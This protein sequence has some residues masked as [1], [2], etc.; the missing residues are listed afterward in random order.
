MAYII[1]ANRPFT[2][3]YRWGRRTYPLSLAAEIQ[4][5]LLPTSPACEAAQFAVAGALEPAGHVGGDAFDYVMDRDHVQLSVTNAMGHDVDTALPATLLVGALRRARRQGADTHTV[6][7]LLK[8]S[9]RTHP[10]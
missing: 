1:I 2:D 10:P 4:Q 5:R 8:V 7:E 9:G 3:L 6:Q